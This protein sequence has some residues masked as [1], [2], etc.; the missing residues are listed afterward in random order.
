[1]MSEVK[2]EKISSES[3]IPGVSKAEPGWGSERWSDGTHNFL[4]QYTP[5]KCSVFPP[6]GF[7]NQ[8]VVDAA[9]VNAIDYELVPIIDGEVVTVGRDHGES[10]MHAVY[11]AVVVNN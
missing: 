7:T 8:A 9:V 2:L 10:L 5:E 3:G 4:L 6:D 11:D 1:M